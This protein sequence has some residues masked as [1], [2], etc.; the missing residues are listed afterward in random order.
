M[1]FLTKTYENL[2]VEVGV[3]GGG[4]LLE[5]SLDGNLAFLLVSLPVGTW[6]H[7]GFED[8]TLYD[9]PHTLLSEQTCL[10]TAFIKEVGFL[11]VSRHAL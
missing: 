4:K 10:G 2:L 11:V 5:G 8:G 9:P 7:N 6:L 1:F 3:K